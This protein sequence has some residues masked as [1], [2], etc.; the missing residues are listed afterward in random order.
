MIVPA[1]QPASGWPSVLGNRMCTISRS[2]LS[3]GAVSARIRRMCSSP[4]ESLPR[5]FT[6]RPMEDSGFIST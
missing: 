5:D 2:G 4:L 3:N 1:S 6:P